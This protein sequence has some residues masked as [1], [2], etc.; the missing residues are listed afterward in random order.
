MILPNR[1]KLLEHLEILDT[2]NAVH[3][4]Q[5]ALEPG[6]LAQLLSVES[7]KRTLDE[8][9]WARIWF[10]ERNAR[11][12]GSAALFGVRQDEDACIRLCT[13]FQFVTFGWRGT[14]ISARLDRKRL[15]YLDAHGLVMIGDVA[16]GN[17]RSLQICQARGFEIL[18]TLDSGAIKLIRFPQVSEMR[19]T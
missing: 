12:V 18:E 2:D 11:I 9:G 6:Q 8:P 7:L 13:G 16:P 10:E 5:P 1:E 17:K 15:D 19:G 4:W 3:R 14:G